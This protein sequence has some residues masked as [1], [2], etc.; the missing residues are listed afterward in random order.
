MT[1]RTRIRT[2]Q[3]RAAA[4]SACH[5]CGGC[6]VTGFPDEQGPAPARVDALGRCRGCG[7]HIKP[8]PQ[9]LLDR[10]RHPGAVVEAT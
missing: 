6:A 5:V 10:L 3:R 9:G 7:S 1:L 4:A 2:L 8:Y